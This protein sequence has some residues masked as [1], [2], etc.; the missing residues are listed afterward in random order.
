MQVIAVIIGIVLGLL[1]IIARL[2]ILLLT[3][4]IISGFIFGFS[5]ITLTMIV[6]IIITFVH[7]A[8]SRR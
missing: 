6:V 5:W 8:I 2:S 1:D 4:T 7:G 3:G